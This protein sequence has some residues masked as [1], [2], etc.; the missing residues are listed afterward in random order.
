MKDCPSG[1]VW[2]KGYTRKDGMR[3]KGKCVK[4]RTT[5]K[6]AIKS[7]GPCKKGKILREGYVRTSYHKK[8]TTCPSKKTRV[9]ATVVPPKCI[10]D[11][12]S[13]GKSEK[14]IVLLMHNLRKCGYTNV[15]SL[16]KAKREKY[17]KK[18]ISRYG[19]VYIIK[20][21]NARYVLNKRTN[22]KSAKIFKEDQKWVSGLY[23]KKQTSM[24][25]IAKKRSPAKKSMKKKSSRKTSK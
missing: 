25:K 8:C 11:R 20:E 6:K 17:L 16:S 4:S 14:M 10:K 13:K 19:H 15:E 12:G 22:P 21:L 9:N 23:A 5:T 18:C 3:V 24:K 7:S 1:Y 2:R